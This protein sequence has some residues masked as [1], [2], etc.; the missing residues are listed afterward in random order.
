MRE[1]LDK[2]YTKSDIAKKCCSIFSNK[3]HVDNKNDV[4]IEP[5]AGD[6]SFV[7]PLKKMC[8]N[9]IFLDIFPEHKDVKRMDFLTTTKEMLCG[10]KHFNNIHVIGNPPFGFKSSD[11]IA[12]INHACSF[13]DTFCFILPKSF[14]KT[15]MKKTVP[16]N[17]HLIHSFV[18]PHNAFRTSNSSYH[19]NCV[20]QIWKKRNS[21]RKISSKQIPNNYSFTNEPLDADIAIRRVGYHAGRIFKNDFIDKN[22]NSHYFVKLNKKKDVILLSSI[23][24]KSSNDVTG[25]KSIS[26]QDI[27]KSLNE[28]LN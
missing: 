24:L 2:Y 5:S 10:E 1:H 8:K 15:S 21:L 22:K 14:N 28:M 13:C 18:L 27:I 16:L 3:I 20:C 11:A 4:V 12:F 19:V 26:K 17:F 7:L 9:R 23:N 6:G 25:P